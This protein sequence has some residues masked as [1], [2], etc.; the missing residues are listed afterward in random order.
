MPMAP[1]SEGNGSSPNGLERHAGGWTEEDL[2]D[3]EA[4]TACLRLIDP[5]LW[6]DGLP[7]PPRPR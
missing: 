2:R 7:E 5:A 3:L 4:A 1:T 6:S